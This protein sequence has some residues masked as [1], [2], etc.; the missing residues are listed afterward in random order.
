VAFDFQCAFPQE[1]IQLNRIRVLRGPPRTLD[2][3]GEDFRSV[4]EV[5]INNIPAVDTVILSKSRLLAQLPDSLQAGALLSVQVLS[6]KLTV[7]PKSVIRFRISKT[8]GRVRGILRLVQLF[9]K[10]LFTTP[11]TDIFNQRLG[12]GGLAK[13]GTTFG[14]DEGSDII[15]DFYISVNTTS[16][17]IIAIQGRDSSIP[18]DERLLSARVLRAGFNKNEGALVVSVE[19]TS[20]AGRVALTNLEF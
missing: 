18:R 20:Q 4:D 8:P 9:L 1:S 19:L 3:I 15:S 6:R 5:F 12:G 10:V 13:I 17:Q 2:I 7:T 14:T 11:G 16:R